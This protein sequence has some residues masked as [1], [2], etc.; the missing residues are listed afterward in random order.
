MNLSEAR[1]IADR[2]LAQLKEFSPADIA[3]NYEITEEHP[4]GYVFFY[5][6]K[7]FWETR[8]LTTS[9][10]GNGPLLVKRETGEIIALPSNQSVKKSLRA[11]AE[12]SR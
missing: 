7:R 3:F 11:V 12:E 9:L 6:T 1:T 8:D 4:I 5:N 10:A 2:Y